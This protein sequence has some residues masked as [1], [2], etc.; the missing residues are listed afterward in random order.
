MGN[1]EEFNPASPQMY[2]I[3]ESVA[4]LMAWK[5][6]LTKRD[7]GGND[8]LVSTGSL[9]SGFWEKGEK[10]TLKRVSG[11]RDAGNTACPGKYLYAQVPGHQVESGADLPQRRRR[12]R[13]HRPRHPGSDHA[14]SGDRRVQL[15]RVRL[16]RRCRPAQGWGPRTGAGRQEGRRYPPAL[17]RRGGSAYGRRTADPAVAPCR[18]ARR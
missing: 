10:A 1:F 12:R 3:K 18:S 11:H 9:N 16:R 6:G 17:P 14:G 4:R 13:L 5:L 2:A 8:T 7:P 15:P